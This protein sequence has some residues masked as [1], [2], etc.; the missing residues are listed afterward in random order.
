MGTR[1]T[2]AQASL[3]TLCLTVKGSVLQLRSLT[4]RV[5]V[6]YGA[7]SLEGG[8]GSVSAPIPPL[9]LAREGLVFSPTFRN[10]MSPSIVASLVFVWL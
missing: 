5:L 10:L 7:S 3:V 2:A 1:E 4:P 8:G 9:S 6:T